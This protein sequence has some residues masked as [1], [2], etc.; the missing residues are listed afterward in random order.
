LLYFLTDHLGSVVAITDA[1]GALLNEQRYMPFGQVRTDVGTID[2]TDFG[3][4]S[5]RNLPDM[6]LMDYKA[7]FYDANIGRFVQPDNTTP[8]A[9]NPWA[10]DR[11]AYTSNNPIVFLDP[12][13][14][15]EI[16]YHQ[17][18]IE[19]IGSA[20]YINNHPNAIPKQHTG[21]VVRTGVD[22]NDYQPIKQDVP[23]GPNSCPAVST[24]FGDEELTNAMMEELNQ[25]LPDDGNPATP[26]WNEAKGG[27]AQPS[28]LEQ[29][30]ENV[31]GMENVSTIAL[32]D[33][34]DIADAL[35]EGNGVVVDLTELPD[36]SGK[37]YPTSSRDGIAHF[38]EVLAVDWDND[39]IYIANTLSGDN[40]WQ[41]SYEEFL[42][43][44]YYPETASGNG[45]P[46]NHWAIIIDFTP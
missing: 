4:T 17:P 7:R 3:Y 25:L 35:D 20:V 13:G 18:M 45:E 40:M 27:G 26:R 37:S 30:A 42:S 44:T 1:S 29:A 41:M 9:S 34:V 16:P 21:T 28:T 38:A 24:G 19:G 2:Q 6:G 15:I 43:Y 5:Q 31:Y 22:L 11:Y 46:V 23:F 12:S 39:I 33:I 10:W 36:S 8:S 14:H 32:V